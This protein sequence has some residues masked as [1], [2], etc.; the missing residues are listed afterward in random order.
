[1]YG[2][3]LLTRRLA[4]GWRQEDVAN[5]IEVKKAAY[6]HYEKETRRPSLAKML[7]L[8]EIFDTNIHDLFG[9]DSSQDI[10]PSNLTKHKSSEPPLQEKVDTLI[11]VL[12]DEH[13]NFNYKIHSKNEVVVENSL[14]LEEK[15]MYFEATDNSMANLRILKGDRLLIRMG[16]KVKS[17][18]IVLI[19][20]NE[21]LIVRRIIKKESTFVLE[22][23]STNDLDGNLRVYSDQI[24]VVGKVEQVIIPL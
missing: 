10:L 17:G 24:R 15:N 12:W 22:T 7:K 2:K 3:N 1:M 13:G 11:D 19:Y 14:F 23:E 9:V 6:C 4:K 20:V 18:D 16:E 8:A 21:S 5:L